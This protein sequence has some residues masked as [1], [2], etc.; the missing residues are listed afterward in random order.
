M[1][2]E[3][4]IV[5]GPNEAVNGDG[6]LDKRLKE[7]VD[8][9]G[10]PLLPQTDLVEDV[11]GWDGQ[12]DPTMPMNFPGS[13]KWLLLGLIAAMNFLSPLTS[14]LPAPGVSEMNIDFHNTDS[15]LT[16]FVI[17]V[18]VL[19]TRLLSEVETYHTDCT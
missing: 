19:G 5:N 16:T 12:D 6:M 11:I 7:A 2:T 18:F 9:L 15:L 8:P 14:T 10:R 4:E 17:S 13:K 3:K 1:D